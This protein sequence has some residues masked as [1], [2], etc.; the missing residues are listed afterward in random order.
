MPFHL[1]GLKKTN[2][3]IVKQACTSKYTKLWTYKQRT[4]CLPSSFLASKSLSMSVPSSSSSSSSSSDSESSRAITSSC[5][6]QMSLNLLPELRQL[7]EGESKQ[8]AKTE[9]VHHLIVY[10]LWITPHLS[11]KGEKFL[12]QREK[13]ICEVKTA[14]YTVVEQIICYELNLLRS[15]HRETHRFCPLCTETISESKRDRQV[16]SLTVENNKPKN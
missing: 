4:L 6:I 5:K 8:G 15:S 11:P 14:P 10:F 16:Q 1:E 13:N 7:T 3:L 2:I 9:K 12:R